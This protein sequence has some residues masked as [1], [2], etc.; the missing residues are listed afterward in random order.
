MLYPLNPGTQ[1]MGQLVGNRAIVD[2]LT[3]F[4]KKGTQKLYKLQTQHPS[5]DIEIIA[6]AALPCYINLNHLRFSKKTFCSS[7]RWH[8]KK[9]TVVNQINYYYFTHSQQIPIIKRSLVSPAP[10]RSTALVTL[11]CHFKPVG[12][13]AIY[14]SGTD[15]RF[16]SGK[17]EVCAC[18][19]LS[20][21]S[22][23]P[24]M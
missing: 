4:L 23:W 20:H 1:W 9:L 11:W 15:L 10:K 13:T 3:I 18:M 8:Y 21:I 12:M 14:R 7:W 2:V 5:L 6:Q 24:Y 16:L 17:F 19:R 22:T